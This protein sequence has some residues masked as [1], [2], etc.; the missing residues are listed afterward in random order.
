LNQQAPNHPDILHL[1]ALATKQREPDKAADYFERS[2]KAN[3]KQPS[4]LSNYANFLQSSQ[5]LMAAKQNYTKALQ[6]NPKLPDAW[7]NLAS[8]H[9]QSRDYL[10]AIEAAT[11]VL[12][13][14]P[15]FKNA[16]IL[17]A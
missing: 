6:I 8:L 5:Q 16:V 1:L 14:K 15:D 2:L 9:Y 13:Q 4:V 10:A 12:Q 11:K 7:Y 17:K 3:P